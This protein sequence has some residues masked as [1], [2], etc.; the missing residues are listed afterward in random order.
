MINEINAFAG[1]SVV[2]TVSRFV[3]GSDGLEFYTGF[4]GTNFSLT[5]G[6]AYY[7]AV[8]SDVTNYVPQHF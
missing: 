6:E 1:G 8:S 3:R 7:V 5:P 2:A 4:S